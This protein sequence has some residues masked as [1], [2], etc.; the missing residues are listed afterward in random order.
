MHLKQ[1]GYY[2]PDYGVPSDMY[3]NLKMASSFPVVLL[4]KNS[5]ITGF[6]KDRNCKIRIVMCAM[7]ISILHDALQIPG[8][9]LNQ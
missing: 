7:I 6:M 1:I 8:F 4:E 9:P 3:F 5:F 2:K